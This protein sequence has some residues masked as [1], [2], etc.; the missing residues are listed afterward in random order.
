MVLSHKIQICKLKTDGNVV[1]ADF[2]WEVNRLG[3]KASKSPP[4]ARRTP[5][6]FS[7]LERSRF[8]K[9]WVFQGAQRASSILTSLAPEILTRSTIAKFQ[10]SY[11]AFIAA[12]I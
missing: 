11:F 9:A 2:S 3:P 7:Y 8:S 4:S 6:G 5:F 1:V 10:L 12:Q